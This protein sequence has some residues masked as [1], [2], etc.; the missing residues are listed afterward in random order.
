LGVVLQHLA[1]VIL[2]LQEK[3]TK[4]LT[5]KKACIFKGGMVYLMM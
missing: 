2:A 3:K 1:G 5:G 4:E